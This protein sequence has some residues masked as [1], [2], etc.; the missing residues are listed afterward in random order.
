MSS[1][2]SGVCSYS[3]SSHSISWSSLFELQSNSGLLSVPFSMKLTDFEG[4]ASCGDS[5][6]T[7]TVSCF[8]VTGLAYAAGVETGSASRDSGSGVSF[9]PCSFSCAALSFSCCFCMAF[10][11]LETAASCDSFCAWVFDFCG[12]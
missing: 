3:I 9:S 6:L 4:L 8:G 11:I 7:S 5:S 1:A 10:L 12:N 2:Q